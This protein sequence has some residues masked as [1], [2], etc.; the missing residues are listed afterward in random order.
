MVL[1]FAKL[2]CPWSS[3]SCNWQ[4]S[5]VSTWMVVNIFPYVNEEDRSE[6]TNVRIEM[7]PIH[8]MSEFFSEPDTGFWI[9]EEYVL[10]FCAIY[11]G[12]STDTTHFQISSAFST[13]SPP[14]Y[15]LDSQQ[16]SESFCFVAFAHFCDV[17]IPIMTNFERQ[18][19]ATEHSVGKR[20]GDSH[21]Y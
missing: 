14:L 6:T 9:L 19:D 11:N 3:R 5:V 10:F 1:V 12:V 18:H 20:T 13:C 4:M 16:N 2:T 17:N 21:Y 15:C 7:S 8:S